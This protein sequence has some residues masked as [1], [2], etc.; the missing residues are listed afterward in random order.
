[1]AP[2]PGRA[3]APASL[4]R[5]R[6]SRGFSAPARRGSFVLPCFSGRWHLQKMMKI[7]RE[8]ER[9]SECNFVKPPKFVKHFVPEVLKSIAINILHRLATALF[10][11]YAI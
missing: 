3:G 1:M 6:R 11:F 7:G 9:E 10:R 2:P 8:R 4:R 5:F